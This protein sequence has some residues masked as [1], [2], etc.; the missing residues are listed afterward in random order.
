VELPDPSESRG[1]QGKSGELAGA[2]VAGPGARPQNVYFTLPARVRGG[3]TC[4]P[5][6]VDWKL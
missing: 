3:I 2:G 1:T 5:P 4:V 6:N